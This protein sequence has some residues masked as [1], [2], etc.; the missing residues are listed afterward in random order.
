M[1]RRAPGAWQCPSGGG[2]G[3][4]GT[5]GRRELSARPPR[6][7]PAG[8]SDA[9]G[10]CALFLAPR[11][12]SGAGARPGRIPSPSTSLG[13]GGAGRSG[14][15][16]ERGRAGPGRA[17]SLRPRRANGG[18]GGRQVA[19]GQPEGSRSARAAPRASPLAP[20]GRGCAAGLRL[21]GVARGRCSGRAAVHGRR[22]RGGR[23]VSV[24]GGAARPRRCGA[25]GRGQGDLKALFQSVLL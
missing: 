14:G 9:G 8:G 18:G 15:G 10:S 21:H 11:N 7:G 22:L 16:A 17:G 12:L 24:R 3:G 23:G 20:H 6:A 2:R 1:R 19:R 25:E 5:R 4:C 13:P